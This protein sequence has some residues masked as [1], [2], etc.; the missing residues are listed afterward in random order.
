MKIKVCGITTVEQ[1]VQL[2]EGGVDYA[3]LIFYPKSKR[4]AHEK[5][6]DQQAAIKNVDII[7]VGVFVNADMDLLKSCIREYNLSAV[8][9]HGDETPE[10]CDALKNEIDVIKVFRIGE[11]A[12]DI[13]E[14]I[15]PFQNSC[16]Y[17]LF[18]TDTTEY[19]GSG[20]RF[21][22]T[23]LQKAI[24]GKPFFLSGGIGPDDIEELQR[25]SHPYLHAI[26]IN[27]RFE[28][29]AGIKNME[30]VQN[31]INQLNALSLWIK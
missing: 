27:S 5:L 18:D 6:N 19:G 12:L 22:W 30:S 20:K 13:D 26:D 15:R 29:A 14:R 10:F 21:D 4:Y 1:L 7:K 11:A 9:L 2:Q 3:G 31:F 24:I 8:Q 23:L 28:T 25:F 17:F 16:A